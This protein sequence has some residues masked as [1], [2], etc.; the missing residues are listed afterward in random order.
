MFNVDE[1]LSALDQLG[2]AAVAAGERLD[3]TVFDGAALMLASNFRFSTEDVDIAEIGIPQPEWLDG[4][5]LRI[6]R[7]RSWSED[8]LNDA[9]TFHLSSLATKRD[10]E[11][12]G[13]F[14]R[15]SVGD[16]GLTVSVPTADYWLALKLKIMRANDPAKGATEI[17][18][19]RALLQATG[20]S[21]V[22]GAIH[23]LAKFFPTSAVASEKQRFLFRNLFPDLA[24]N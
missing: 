10:H 15:A 19:I 4:A 7:S 1:L 8:W 14:P 3:V 17:K 9:V 11:I 21:T 12:F 24:G 23:C 20:I 18:E 13:S 5:V 22:D 6:A 16:V 2:E